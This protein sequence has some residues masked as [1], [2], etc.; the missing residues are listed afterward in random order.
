[1]LNMP[2]Q[3]ILQEIEK[4]QEAGA[5]VVRIDELLT[6]PRGLEP[7][8]DAVI[9]PTSENLPCEALAVS[10][11]QVDFA[12]AA[13]P[14]QD[15]APE[16]VLHDLSFEL[17]PGRV[18]GLLGRTGSGKTTISRLLARLYDPVVGCVALGGV[19]LRTLSPTLIRRH[20]GV[21]TQNVQIFHATVRENLTFFDAAIPDEQIIALLQGTRPV[22]LV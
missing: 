11:E 17:A 15:T 20:V 21:V 9:Q 6:T 5:G 1:M 13:L 3:R 10:F 22:E 14:G 19:D 16:Y 2:I 7:E 8:N 4:L 18:M 12:Y